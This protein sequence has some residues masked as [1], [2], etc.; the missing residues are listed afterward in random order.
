MG[1]GAYII[2]SSNYAALKGDSLKD[3]PDSAE[4]YFL[5]AAAELGLPGLAV[6]L[7]FFWEIARKGWRAWRSMPPRAPD[8][9]LLAGTLS[10]LTAFAVNTLTHSYIGSFEV[11]YTFWLF[12]AAVFV[13]G[14]RPEPSAAGPAPSGPRPARK[15][16]TA[17]AL[18][19]FAYAGILLWVS[20]HSLS[21]ARTTERFPIP[22]EVGL[23]KPEKTQGGM[24]FRW[25]R[26]YGGWP[27]RIESRTLVVPIHASHPDLAARPVKVRISIAPDAFHRGR[28]VKEATVSSDDWREVEIGLPAEEVGQRR[29]LFFDV[30]R[31][32]NPSKTTGAP[33]SRNLGIA[34]G[35]IRFK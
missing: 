9:W 21:L 34:V 11:K 7:W 26:E 33:D 30:D 8:R 27:V 22:G 24:D 10:G 13:L 2:E 19:V 14:G 12:V 25:T 29:L 31:T 28:V 20:T 23:A 6:F 32:W 35:P 3:L 1:I 17:D 15:R 5:Q 4:N 16:R 18:A